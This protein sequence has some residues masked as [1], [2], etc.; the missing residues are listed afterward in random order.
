[1][2]SEHEK[3]E[4]EIQALKERNFRVEADKAWEV[5]KVRIASISLITY[6]IA[7]AFLYIIGVKGFLLNA[8]VPAVGYYLSTQSLPFVKSWWIQKNWK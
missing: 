2:L 6:V 5:S 1:M 8:L 7:A 3:L 4:K